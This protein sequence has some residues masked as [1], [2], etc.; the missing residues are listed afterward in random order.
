MAKFGSSGITCVSHRDF[1]RD[2]GAGAVELVGAHA[3][4][5]LTAGH[6]GY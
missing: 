2:I 5:F 4:K 1:T 6:E 3:P